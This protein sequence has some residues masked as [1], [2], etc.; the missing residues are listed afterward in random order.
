MQH[1]L[2]SRSLLCGMFFIIVVL[3]LGI[4]S[5]SGNA[6][7]AYPTKSYYGYSYAEHDWGDWE[8]YKYGPNY[9]MFA[10]F[11]YDG[12]DEKWCGWTEW[13]ISSIPDSAQIFDVGVRF[14]VTGKPD[15]C[16]SQWADVDIFDMANRPSTTGGDIIENQASGPALTLWN[17]AG[18]GNQYVDWYSMSS[19]GYY[20]SSSSYLDL[21][22]LADSDLESRLAVNWFA[23]GIIDNDDEYDEGIK[24]RTTS[25]R[26]KYSRPPE[27]Y[28]SG[29]LSY[30]N[31]MYPGIEYTVVAEYHD[32]DGYDDLRYCWLELDND[33]SSPVEEYL[34]LRWEDG[35]ITY[36]D[37]TDSE[38][39]T[40]L[41]VSESSLGATTTLTW[42]FMLDW[43][44]T[45]DTGVDLG[46]KV[47]DDHGL[48]DG[49]VW[50][51][52]NLEYENDIFLADL[53]VNCASDWD[54]GDVED[55]DWIGPSDDVTVSGYFF[56]EGSIVP[57]PSGEIVADI[58]A[59]G[60]YTG[61]SDA[62]D[63][64]GYFFAEFSSGSSTDLDYLIDVV[65]SSIPSGG[66]EVASVEDGISARI[67]AESPT[68]PEP[69]DGVE[70]WS[71]DNTP[72]F[73]WSASDNHS[74]I[75]GFY[76]KIDSGVETWTN[77]TQVTLPE[78]S[79]GEHV[80][81][82]KAEDTVGNNGS[83]GEHVFN[84]DT[85]APVTICTL[86]GVLEGDVYIS[87]VTVTLDA[88]DEL[89]GVQV[90]MYKRNDGAWDVYSEAFVVSDSGQHTVYY[91]SI[92]TADNEE[93]EQENT[94][95]IGHPPDTPTIDG[96]STG[97]PGTEYEYT[98]AS[99]DSDGD[100]VYYLVDW[101]D[102]STQEWMG[103]YTSGV[104]VIFSHT[105]PEDG[106]YIIRVKAKDTYDLESAWEI[107]EVTM[108]RN[109]MLHNVFLPRLLE[110]FP[111]AFPILRYIFRLLG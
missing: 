1:N 25:F 78:Q 62:C 110:R 8:Y 18:D 33:A 44:W 21:G 83:F 13:D 104:E 45:E 89:S 16:D 47:E 102:G 108:P 19:N 71:H 80:F 70:G 105:W 75:G 67:D 38:Y 31:A 24:V 10:G 64:T 84:I 69:D 4:F 23:I 43:D 34:D 79:E 77:L 58:Y 96:P 37:P 81:Y 66:S 5:M 93:D 54:G 6:N 2:F 12:D 7:Y 107:L 3:F 101:G 111:N 15:A 65:A 48:D 27:V 92:D 22:S 36:V 85:T 32:S 53:T 56:Y 72:T 106:S 97:K 86:A 14:E 30:P 109:T 103:P 61:V 94:F 90:T 74:G 29:M 95:I 40:I 60:S 55:T 9:Y 91:Y 88:T 57:P 76:W 39:I 87:N 59:N 20:P 68:S 17:D 82:V 49:W 98:V 50:N 26:V 63:A 73:T 28:S 100:A 46:L 42:N 11:D 35:G 52:V 99:V 41:S 51:D